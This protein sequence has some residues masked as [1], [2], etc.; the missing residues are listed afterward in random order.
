[1][2]GCGA[3]VSRGGGSGSIIMYLRRALHGCIY[4]VHSIQDR[5]H[6]VSS[7]ARSSCRMLDMGSY[8]PDDHQSA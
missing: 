2:L 3:G 7:P 8:A 1:M 4:H 5:D 6:A